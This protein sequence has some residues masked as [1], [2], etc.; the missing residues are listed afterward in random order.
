MSM[1][2]PGKSYRKG[3][4][5]IDLFEMF[6]DDEAAEEWFVNSR[7]PDGIRCAHCESDNITTESKHPT[8]PFH[9]RECR[10]F[11][12]A[13][14]GTV[15]HSSKLGYR[16][17]AIAIY[18]LTTNI[19]GTSSMKLHRD[20]NVSQKTAWH[21]AHRIRE[22]WRKGVGTTFSGPVEVDET[23]IGG[24]EKNKHASKKLR[25]GRGTVGKTP[26][27]GIKD[28]E[29]NQVQTAVTERTDKPTLQG[30]VLDHTEPFTQVYT[31]EAKAY[32]GI[33]RPHEAVK[34]SVGEYVR[35]QAHT[36]GMESHWALLKRG[37]EGVYH[38]MSVKHL[39]RYVDEFA[40]RH[41]H[42]PLDTSEQ[43]TEMVKGS[44]GKRL[45]YVD[46]IGAE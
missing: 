41:N 39:G 10:K 44:V 18:I 37:Y 27:V 22:T 23:Y 17:W 3:M 36:N 43:M 25:A 16:K 2:G 35:E 9:C 24:K 21:M 29:T 1:K 19:K 4:S 45:R 20:I 26:V 13:K 42:R 14:T 12:S 6:P 33:N 7:W 28:R 38:H 11:F 15:M 30:F 5:L 8:M 31:D 32:Q 40:G 34:H 46:L